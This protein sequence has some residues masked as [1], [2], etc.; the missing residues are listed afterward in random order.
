MKDENPG[1][2]FLEM[3]RKIGEKWRALDSDERKK[4]EEE[5]GVLR[6]SYLEKKKQ[7]E[8]ENKKSEKY[9]SGVGV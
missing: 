8:N 2:E 1:I 7:W 4:F 9:S 5:A 3:G 6:S